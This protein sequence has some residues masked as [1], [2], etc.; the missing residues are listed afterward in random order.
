M[1]RQ[2]VQRLYRTLLKT[3]RKI[4]DDH[5]RRDFTEQTRES[6][7]KHLHEKNE[8]ST[9][10]FLAEIGDHHQIVDPASGP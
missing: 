1:H 10:F 2:R 4:P 9:S 5:Y 6:F 3:A 8:V 7:R